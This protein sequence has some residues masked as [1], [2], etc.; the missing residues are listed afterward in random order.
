METRIL[1]GL[2]ACLL[3]QTALLLDGPM[4]VALVA[5]KVE[6]PSAVIL[7]A[8]GALALAEVALMSVW[9]WAARTAYAIQIGAHVSRFERTLLK[10]AGYSEELQV[11]AA[12]DLMGERTARDSIIVLGLYWY[13]PQFFT[14]A[15]V[16]ALLSIGVAA[17][18]VT[19]LMSQGWL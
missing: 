13:A 3:A 19:I 16:M 12:D 8:V 1:L 14:T 11:Q 2:L 9:S 7:V 10:L 17:R 15:V 5:G 18:A 4:L 6:R